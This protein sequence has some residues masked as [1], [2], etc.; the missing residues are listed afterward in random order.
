MVEMADKA[1]EFPESLVVAA[2][3]V[4]PGVA[5]AVAVEAAVVV[6]GGWPVLAVPQDVAR[7]LNAI[8][9]SSR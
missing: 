3:A 7:K 6:A 1:L 9:F 8:A 5:Q 2:V 4:F